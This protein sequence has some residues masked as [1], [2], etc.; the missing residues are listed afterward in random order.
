MTTMTPAG[1]RR[2]RRGFTLVELLMVMAVAGVLLAMIVPVSRSLYESSNLTLGGQTVNDLLGVA[3]QYAA[4]Q[5]QTVEVRF[6]KPDAGANGFNVVQLWRSA[7]AGGSAVPLDKATMLPSNIEISANANLSP[8]LD[9]NALAGAVSTMPTGGTT[10]GKPYVFF[11]IR[12]NGNVQVPKPQ[13]GATAADL[14]PKY[15]FTLLAARYDTG[16]ILPT[17]YLIIQINPDTAS[18]GVFQP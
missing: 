1:A 6:I 11:T 9:P 7:P 16:G 15:F 14:E 4:S 8:I 2:I 5:N 18:T 13:A 3:R 10:S 12:P 17:N